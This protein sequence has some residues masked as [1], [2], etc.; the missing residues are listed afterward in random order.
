MSTNRIISPSSLGPVRCSASSMS[1]KL[2]RRSPA[3]NSCIG[4]GR[5]SSNSVDWAPRAT[6]LPRFGM[7]FSLR[8]SKQLPGACLARPQ[9]VCTTTFKMTIVSSLV[10]EG[11]V[12]LGLTQQCVEECERALAVETVACPS[13][14]DLRQFACFWKGGSGS[15]AVEIMR[16]AVDAANDDL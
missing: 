11:E 10:A 3:S 16:H 15:S 14:D 5:V 4:S 9:N 12:W 13:S 6:R 8:D 7:R 1:A 2:Q